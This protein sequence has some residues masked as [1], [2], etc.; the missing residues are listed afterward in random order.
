MKRGGKQW[1]FQIRR[2]MKKADTPAAKLEFLQRWA[3]FKRQRTDPRSHASGDVV[4]A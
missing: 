1:M 2:E 4:R 3:S